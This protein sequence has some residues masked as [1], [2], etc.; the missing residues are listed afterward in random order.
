MVLKIKKSSGYTLIELLI[1]MSIFGIIVS[2]VFGTFNI[3]INSSK[4]IE[5]D[6]DFYK[7]AQNCIKIMSEDLRTLYIS[8]PPVYI[9]PE[10][11]EN[12][13]PYRIICEN[14]QLGSE[15]YANLRF[16]SYNHFPLNKD[17]TEGITEIRY[18]VT[19]S[20]EGVRVLRRSDR[21]N[22]YDDIFEENMIDPVIC[23]NIKFL[24]L[25]FYNEKGEPFEDWD[26]E[27]QEF[28]LATP[29]AVDISIKV[30]DDSSY[31]TLLT[32]INFNLYREAKK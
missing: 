3:I 6:M 18:Y 26:S 22:F 24:S 2:I 31:V 21:I 1:A 16:T 15:S 29:K 25:K 13:D 11:N 27:S 5:Q 19:E 7:S 4:Q 28:N 10:F 9:S 23:E 20:N 17:K 30:G 8:F 32:S 14:K 12:P